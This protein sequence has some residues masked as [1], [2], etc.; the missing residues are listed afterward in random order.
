MT[1]A[2]GKR[3]LAG[4]AMQVEDVVNEVL[5]ELPF[6]ER[7][8]VFSHANI[9]HT[10]LRY[11]LPGERILDFGAGACDKTAVV[12]KLG[13][14]C[15]AC[16]DLGD[17]WH[18][19]PGVRERI[20][21]YA[22]RVGIRF[23]DTPRSVLDLEAESFDM[24]M[25]HDVIEHLHDSPRELLAGLVGLLRPGGHLFVTVPNAVNIRKRLAVLGGRTNLPSFEYYFWHPGAWR[26]HVREYVR[27]D[28]QALA[29][30]LGL[31]LR[32]LKSC[33]N[34]LHRVPR[35]LQPLYVGLTA[36][37]PGWRDSWL[38]VARKPAGW[39]PP[40]ALTPQEFDA[41]FGGACTK[42]L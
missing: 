12:Q 34:M 24:V 18:S 13:F 20:L 11:Q 31:E 41:R 26:G 37:F 35:F 7:I 28:L 17:H 38:L 8:G 6:P 30:L 14:Q 36:L 2:D 1:G 4:G 42:G 39:R 10:V 40:V 15:T 5:G 3:A 27:G 32:E 23:L 29:R 9:A 19:L 16:D 33:H 25:L 22:R 21:E